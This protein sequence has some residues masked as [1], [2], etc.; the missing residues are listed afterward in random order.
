MQNNSLILLIII[1]STSISL[2]FFVPVAKKSYLL[3]WAQLLI[4]IGAT[5]VGSLSIYIWA[6]LCFFHLEGSMYL[7]PSKYRS[8][9]SLTI[10]L[11][12]VEMA[13]FLSSFTYVDLIIVGLFLYSTYQLN[14]LF[15]NRKEQ[16]DLYEKLLGEYRKLKRLLY[17]TE[18]H[19]KAEE[20][21]RIARDIH[22]SVGH[23]L[24]ALLMKIEMLS[25]QHGKAAYEDLKQLA[26]D[27]LEETREAVSTLKEGEV[28]GIQSVLQLIRKL[29]SESHIM[30]QLTTQQGVLSTPL[31]NKQNIVLFRSI[32]EGITNAMRHAHVREVKVTLGKTAQGHL[33]LKIT[34]HIQPSKPFQPGFGLKNMKERVEELGGKIDIH[35]TSDEFSIN[36]SFPL[37]EAE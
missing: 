32:Q 10:I 16:R 21:T 34:N 30:I 17:V 6:L 18:Q 1:Y 4:I 20:R 28:T 22:D 15:H 8:F 13:I 25:I 19:S 11:I 36:S 35:Q 9:L 26:K 23:K 37:K 33:S 14:T 29:E 12:G 24:T 5:L 2:F 31:T 3:Y 7:H 27:S